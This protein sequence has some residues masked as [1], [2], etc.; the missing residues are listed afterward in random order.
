M[1]ITNMMVGG[2][3]RAS[4]SKSDGYNNKVFYSKERAIRDKNKPG[5]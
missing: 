4:R 1:P 5:T 2:K 3:E